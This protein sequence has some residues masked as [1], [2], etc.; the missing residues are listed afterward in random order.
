M[1]EATL[2]FPDK[3]WTAA[4]YGLAS[5]RLLVGNPEVTVCNREKIGESAAKTRLNKMAS[6]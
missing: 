4:I 3:N 6:G 1:P 5:K 2:T